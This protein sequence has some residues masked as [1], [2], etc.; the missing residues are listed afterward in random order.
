LRTAPLWGVRFRNHLM[1]DGESTTLR[2]AI[3]R[4]K[5]EARDSARRFERLSAADKQALLEFL[6]SL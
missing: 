1:H 4:H 2:D 6:S 3:R 5:K